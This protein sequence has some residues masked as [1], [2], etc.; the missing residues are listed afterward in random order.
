MKSKL[1][2]KNILIFIFLPVLFYHCAGAEEARENEPVFISDSTAKLKELT[3]GL[4]SAKGLISCTLK[5]LIGEP[6]S[7][8]TIKKDQNSTTTCEDRTAFYNYFIFDKNESIFILQTDP[9]VFLY[10]NSREFNFHL[11]NEFNQFKNNPTLGAD[12]KIKNSQTHYR[13]VGDYHIALT[14]VPNEVRYSD[15]GANDGRIQDRNSAT[16]ED[17]WRLLDASDEAIV[18]IPGTFKETRLFTDLYCQVQKGRTRQVYTPDSNL[19]L[20]NLPEWFRNSSDDRFDEACYNAQRNDRSTIRPWYELKADLSSKLKFFTSFGR[21]LVINDALLGNQ[22]IDFADRLG[23]TRPFAFFLTVPLGDT[24]DAAEANAQD[25]L[26]NRHGFAVQIRGDV[27]FLLEDMKALGLPGYND[28]FAP[29]KVLSSVNESGSI[30]VNWSESADVQILHYATS[31]EESATTV[32][33]KADTDFSTV[34][35]I[36][37]K[38]E[39]SLDVVS[40]T[41]SCSAGT[42]SKGCAHWFRIKGVTTTPSEA[43]AVVPR[44]PAADEVIFTE[45]MWSGTASS[46]DTDSYDEWYEIKNDASEIVNLSGLDFYNGGTDQASI[47]FGPNYNASATLDGHESLGSAD[48]DPAAYLYP[49]EYA[50]IARKLDVYFAG[51]SGLKIF[52]RKTDNLTNGGTSL[53]IGAGLTAGD[54]TDGNDTDGSV[55]IDKKTYDGSFGDNGTPKKSMVLTT[56]GGSR[57]AAGDGSWATSTNDS[58]EPAANLN[59]A[60]PGSAATGEY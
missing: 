4:D 18:Y 5:D 45:I 13:M 27:D 41:G 23:M 38:N 40:A 14:F 59:F 47:V 49:G 51:F 12:E 50:V 57:A 33:A 10:I 32:A 17:Y 22:D 29:V 28:S 37:G 26:S 35:N 44:E 19:T 1:N 11:T 24:S 58:N 54:L 46:T 43:V 8:L 52:E 53:Y 7:L 48:T 42:I 25:Y 56:K 20:S 30:R 21:K 6:G 3:A 31:S 60:S 36:S 15:R 39:T 9:L 16:S 2:I 55:T 34:A